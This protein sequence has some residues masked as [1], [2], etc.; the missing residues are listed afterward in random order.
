MNLRPTRLLAI[1]GPRRCGL[2]NARKRS[3]RATHA[4][5]AH[6]SELVTLSTRHP[7]SKIFDGIMRFATRSMPTHPY[8]HTCVSLLLLRGKNI[9][10]MVYN[11]LTRPPGC[12]YSYFNKKRKQERC[13]DGDMQEPSTTK[14][15]PKATRSLDEQRLVEHLYARSSPDLV[16]SSL[17]KIDPGG[18]LDAQG[19]RNLGDDLPRE[20]GMSLYENR[21]GRLAR[22]ARSESD[23]G[24]DFPLEPKYK[25]K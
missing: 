2:L 25:I 1:S 15:A 13:D 21:P 16:E 24:D 3:R 9:V 20:V 6:R 5:A 22:R 19:R 10:K 4:H 14:C 23:L 11:S 8:S 7:Y 17:T 12:K 18:S